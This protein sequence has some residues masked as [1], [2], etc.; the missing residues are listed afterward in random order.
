MDKQSQPAPP[1]CILPVQKPVYHNRQLLQYA[2]PIT[3]TSVV[4][5]M[6]NCAYQKVVQLYSHAAVRSGECGWMT[7]IYKPAVT[8]HE[9]GGTV[10]VFQTGN[11]FG[12]GS[13]C[14]SSD[15]DKSRRKL[16]V[17]SGNGTACIRKG[18]SRHLM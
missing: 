15:T 6:C 10:M 3:A 14:V 2:I 5:G 9:T 1:T 4:P 11:H 17:F 18:G 13:G 12:S 7:D 16:A 8:L